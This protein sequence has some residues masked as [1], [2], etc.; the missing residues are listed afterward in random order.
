MGVLNKKKKII[1]PHSVNKLE[2]FLKILYFEGLIQAYTKTK[3]NK[4]IIWPRYNFKGEPLFSDIKL[5]PTAKQ[6]FKVSNKDSLKIKK[7]LSEIFIFHNKTEF[8][9]FSSSICKKGGSHIVTIK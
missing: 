4:F 1:L 3:C 9:T 8:F 5:K 2:S 7:K 6:V